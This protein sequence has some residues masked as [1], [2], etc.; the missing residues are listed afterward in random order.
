MKTFILSFLILLVASGVMG[1]TIGRVD[2]KTKEFY[3]APD[4][5]MAYRVFG[6]QFANETTRKMICFSSSA[7]DVRDNYNKCPFGS[8]FNTNLLKQGDRIVYLGKTGNF[9]KMNFIDGSGKKTIFYLPK[10]AFV[11]K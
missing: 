5:K 4:Q 3:V 8:Y 10:S 6:Y 1:Q 7:N 9:G 11:I 2:K